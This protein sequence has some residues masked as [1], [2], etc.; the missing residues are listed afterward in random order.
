ML[1]YEAD[2]IRLSLIR[3]SD[4]TGRT[5]AVKLE[6]VCTNRHDWLLTASAP[7]RDRVREREREERRE[8]PEERARGNVCNR[9]AAV[10]R[11][12]EWRALL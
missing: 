4:F 1:I 9:R 3:E 10:R 8:D 2:P 12:G 11:R 7:S 5:A 6:L